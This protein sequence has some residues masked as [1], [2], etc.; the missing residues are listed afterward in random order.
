M[1]EISEIY[2]YI[3]HRDPFLFVDKI[4]L[5]K[6]GK[7]ALTLKRLSGEE[8]FFKGHFP[9]RPIMPGVLIVEALAQTAAAAALS[10][11]EN[12]GKDALLTGIDKMRFE[13]KVL[14]GDCLES[15]C[16]IISCKLGFIKV[17]A[18]ARV[19]G[20]IVAEGTLNLALVT[21]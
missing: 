17:C 4:V 16:E 5:L 2:G 3:P 11:E 6:P 20:E 9:G 10:P 1:G 8:A 21:P 14:P 7:R 13:K 15:D 19:G 12:H 18:T